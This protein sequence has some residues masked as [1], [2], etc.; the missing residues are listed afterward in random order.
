MAHLNWHIK[1]VNLIYLDKSNNQNTPN[2]EP[3]I[4]INLGQVTTNYENLHNY[5]PN[6]LLL[7]KLFLSNQKL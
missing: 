1:P 7:E 2:Y 3:N 6:F 4:N 5:F